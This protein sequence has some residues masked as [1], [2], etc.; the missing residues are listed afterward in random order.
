MNSPGIRAL[1]ITT[2]TEG[3]SVWVAPHLNEPT[4]LSAPAIHRL[5][6]PLTPP[7]A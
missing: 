2:H 1:V 4:V 7:S 3:Q 5:P 6:G